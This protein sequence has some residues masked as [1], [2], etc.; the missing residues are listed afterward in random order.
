MTYGDG[1]SVNCWSS[2]V[3]GL[4]PHYASGVGNH[5]FYLLAEG[6]ENH[7]R[8]R[9]QRDRLQRRHAQRHRPGRRSR[10]L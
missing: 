3:A 10:D 5:L 8:P 2:S 9:A 4:D 7:R 6:T 1:G